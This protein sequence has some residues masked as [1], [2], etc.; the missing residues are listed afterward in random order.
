M[1]EVT[2]I[3]YPVGQGCFH[4]GYIEWR[5]K[6]QDGSFHYVYDCGSKNSTALKRSVKAMS[7]R[8]PRIDAL[9]VSHLHEDHVNGLDQLL[10]AVRVNTVFIPHLS[11]AATV[12][13]LVADSVDGAL[14]H[15]LVDASLDPQT[16]FGERGVSRIVRV[17]PPPPGEGPVADAGSE[18]LPAGREPQYAEI[19]WDPRETRDGDV[20]TG[21]ADLQ[22]MESGEMLAPGPG[23]RTLDWVLV[24]HVDPELQ[25]DLTRFEGEVANVLGLSDLEYLTTRQLADT[26][27][28]AGQCRRLRD[29]YTRC[30]GANHNRVS[31]SVYSGPNSDP[32]QQHWSRVLPF[33]LQFLFHRK[34]AVGWIGT[35]DA[36]LKDHQVRGAWERSYRKFLP[37]LSTL[38]LPH[39]GSDRNFSPELLKY[40]DLA[41]SIAS[42]GDPSQYSHPGVEVIESVRLQGRIFR[43]V[44][45]RPSTLFCERLEE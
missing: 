17:R 4:A 29:C 32:K 9:F 26:L 25:V 35:G 45:E 2:R 27:R 16:W 19:D 15:S 44:S 38:L 3:Q 21:A 24:P 7:N 39:H 42:A 28:D 11:V 31:M 30:F 5:R 34:G 1:I 33:P 36:E 23:A 10:A 8:H 41:C 12:A 22:W 6:Q 14:S 20:A 43:H 18:D 40:Q 37:N 13:G